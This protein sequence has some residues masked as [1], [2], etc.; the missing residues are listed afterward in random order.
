MWR[1]RGDKVALQDVVVNSYRP[2]LCAFDA[3]MDCIHHEIQIKAN[4]GMIVDV[5]NLAT[6]RHDL[7]VMGRTLRPVLPVVR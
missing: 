3:L 4:H 5:A 7:V 2:A 1:W 6:M